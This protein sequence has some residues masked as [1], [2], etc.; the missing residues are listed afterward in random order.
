MEK[1]TKGENVVKKSARILSKWKRNSTIYG[2]PMVSS[3]GREVIIDF[4]QYHH[5]ENIM[6]A[7]S[8]FKNEKLSPQTEQKESLGGIT[9]TG[10]IGHSFVKT[11]EFIAG[12]N[13]FTYVC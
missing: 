11:D 7:T 12:A 8:K 10:L 2:Q 9:E 1:N 6:D 13:N 5:Q 3:M 4:H